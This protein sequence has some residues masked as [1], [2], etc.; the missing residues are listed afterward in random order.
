MTTADIATT[1][2]RLCEDG[3]N[4]EALE[5]LYGEEVVSVE[6]F[7]SPGFEREVRGKG[8]VRDKNEA[9][10]AMHQIEQSTVTGPFLH[11][12]HRFAVVFRF[13]GRNRQSGQPFDMTEVAVYTVEDGKISREEFYYT[14]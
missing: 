8:P 13:A 6:A 5:T 11:G 2:C 14:P 3:R 7:G 4:M 9:W 12:D 10:G 1:L